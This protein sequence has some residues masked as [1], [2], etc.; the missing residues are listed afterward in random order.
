M[1]QSNSDLGEWDGPT[2]GQL[3]VLTTNGELVQCHACG[4]WFGHLGAHVPKH[5][6]TV[7]E[8]KATFGLNVTTGLIGPKLASQRRQH[9]DHLAQYRDAGR[10]ALKNLRPDQRSRASKRLQF[11]LNE[12]WEQ[13]NADVRAR[14]NAVFQHLLATGAIRLPR[15]SQAD[16]RAWGRKGAEAVQK[17]NEDPA[18]KAQWQQ[19]ISDARG[20][21]I[22]VPCV[23]CGGS[24][25]TTPSRKRRVCNTKACLSEFRRRTWAERR[26]KA[27][28]NPIGPTHRPPIARP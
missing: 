28:E 8:Y 16:L 24:I 10:T 26:A 19:A 3:G 25:E 9:V 12:G 13:R 18:L 7:Q 4:K 2:Y 22:V 1:K 27:Q 21:R 15:H 17:R 20:G 5:G 11:H 23:V 14:A 6:L